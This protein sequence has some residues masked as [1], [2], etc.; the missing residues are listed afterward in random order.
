MT[1][2]QSPAATRRIIGR[3][4]LSGR[5]MTL[6]AMAPAAFTVSGTKVDL[7]TT[8][9]LSAYIIPFTFCAPRRL[10][11]IGWSNAITSAVSVRAQVI[12]APAC[13]DRSRAPAA[14]ASFHDKRFEPM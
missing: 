5:S 9:R 14:A 7:S 6:P 8:S 4:C 1:L 11:M 10:N 12:A 13:A 3:G 2:R